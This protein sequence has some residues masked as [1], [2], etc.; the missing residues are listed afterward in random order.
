MEVTLEVAVFDLSVN[1][2]GVEVKKKK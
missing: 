1:P 2:L